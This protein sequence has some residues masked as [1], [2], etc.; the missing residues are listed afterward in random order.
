MLLSTAY[1][2]PISWMALLIQNREAE[3]EVHEHFEKQSY[4]NRCRIYGPNGAQNLTIP[5]ERSGKTKLKELRIS[6]AEDWPALHWRSIETAYK[7]RPFFDVLAPD[8]KTILDKK[9]SFLLDLNSELLRILLDWLQDD[10]KLDHTTSFVPPI[11]ATTDYRYILHPKQ[12]HIADSYPPYFQNFS[13]KHGFIPDLSTIDLVFSEGRA[14]W[15]Y[16]NELDIPRKS[17][18]DV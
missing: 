3:L 17:F 11:N 16:L 5:V 15:D 1:L 10:V 12:P 6:Y 13:A 2:P 18:C 8:I 14:A 4:R 7:G 9:L